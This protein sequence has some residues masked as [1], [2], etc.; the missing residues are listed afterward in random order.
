M[1]LSKFATLA[2]DC[3]S[4]GRVDSTF[5]AASRA[6]PGRSSAT[7]ALA[8]AAAGRRRQLPSAAN[9]VAVARAGPDV[10]T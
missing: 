5:Q 1:S 6:G 9:R 2:R 10:V 8:A 7:Q 3:H 4:D